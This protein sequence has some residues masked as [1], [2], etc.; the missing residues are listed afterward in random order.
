MK[1]LKCI[2]LLV[3]ILIAFTTI[4][5]LCANTDSFLESFDM[6]N[7]VAGK[8]GTGDGNENEWNNAFEGKKA[9]DAVLSRPHFAMT[10]SFGN[11]YIVDKNAHAIRKVDV[12][13]IIF[14]VAGTNKA[15]DGGEG[16]AVKMELNSPNGLWVNKKG[17]FYILDLG[18]DKIRKVD[19][20]G[21]MVTMFKDDEGISVG[22]GLWLNEAEDT[23]WYCSGSKIK[24]WT[25]DNGIST[26]ASGFNAL[27]NI[28]QD[29]EGYII[30]TDRS[31]NLVYRISREGVKTVIAGNGKTSGGGEGFSALETAFYGVRGIWFVDNDSYLIATHEGSQVWYVDNG[32]IVHL[33]LDGKEGDEYHS[34]DGENYKTEGYKVSEVRAV[35]IDYQG[36]VLVTEN[37]RG[38]IRKIEK[39][40]SFAINKVMKTSFRNIQLK[41]NPA[42]GLSCLKFYFSGKNKIKTIIYNQ[43]GQKIEIPMNYKIKKRNYEIWWEN[44]NLSFGTYFIN[45]NTDI[46]SYSGKFVNIR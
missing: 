24:M 35:T 29:P 5:D 1:Q 8:G 43:L 33:F 12:N 38:F 20:E 17:E 6:L 31:A 7:T 45:I 3:L 36:N 22:R 19:S 25:E 30:A 46:S 13:G 41:V 23:V 26:Y 39:R 9:V 27:G 34:G 32:G 40:S 10:D 44:Q 14:T 42:S 11:I 2:R 37:D 4:Q 15:G 21:N 16:I 18:N 28:V